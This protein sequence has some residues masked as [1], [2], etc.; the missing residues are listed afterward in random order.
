MTQIALAWQWAKGVAAPIVGSTKTSHLDEAV[1]A[2]S[3]KL[4]TADI[5]YL[6][7]LYRPHPIVGALDHNPAAGTIL[8]DQKK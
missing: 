4:T 7:D 8:I 5:D 3:V 6:E 1:A 2:L